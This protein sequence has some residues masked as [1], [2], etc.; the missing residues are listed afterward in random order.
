MLAASEGRGVNRSR[1]AR[2]HPSL[3]ALRP[4]GAGDLVSVGAPAE[5]QL[6]LERGLPHGT[7]MIRPGQSEG[8]LSHP[9]GPGPQ[10]P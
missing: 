2:P 5:C 6:H 1:P 4:L 9:P 3:A 10:S 8:E 7:S